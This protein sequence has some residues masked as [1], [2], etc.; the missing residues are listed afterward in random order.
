LAQIQSAEISFNYLGQFD[1]ILPKS[2]T[3]ALAKESKGAERS[4]KGMRS[5]KLDISGKIIS[6]R[7]SMDWSYSR[8]I[9]ERATIEKLANDYLAE[10]RTLIAHCR[11][12][13]AGGYTPSDFADAELSQEQVEAVLIELSEDA[14]NE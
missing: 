6:G 3:F 14:E 9:H 12:V 10:L 4:P 13:E 1:Q 2:A 7:L 8:N 11:T 5:H